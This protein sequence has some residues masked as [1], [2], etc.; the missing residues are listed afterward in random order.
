MSIFNS[1]EVY[2]G[3]SSSEFYKAKTALNDAGIKYRVKQRRM[4]RANLFAPSAEIN[5]SIQNVI[6]VDGSDADSARYFI[7]KALHDKS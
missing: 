4:G 1:E 2:I 3:Y 7:N 5:Y 6:S